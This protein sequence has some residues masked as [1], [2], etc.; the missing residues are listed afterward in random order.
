MVRMEAATR[1]D[2]AVGGWM[3]RCAEPQLPA[4]CEMWGRRGKGMA[5]RRTVLGANG[6]RKGVVGEEG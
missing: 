6:E 5:R 1:Q 3:L 2:R 4:A